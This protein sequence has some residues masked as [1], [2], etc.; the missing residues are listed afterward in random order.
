MALRKEPGLCHSLVTRLIV[1]FINPLSLN[2]L[3][4]EMG[5]KPPNAKG[6]GDDRVRGRRQTF[7]S[8]TFI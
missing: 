3:I 5:M 1:L 8:S 4:C 6:Y 7:H 2:F